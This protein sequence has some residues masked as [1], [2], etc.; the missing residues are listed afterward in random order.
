MRFNVVP[1]AYCAVNMSGQNSSDKVNITFWNLGCRILIIRNKRRYT[2]SCQKCVILK[3]GHYSVAESETLPK[4]I[5]RAIL[6]LLKK[7]TTIPL[8]LT[9]SKLHI[10]WMLSIVSD[11]LASVLQC[12]FHLHRSIILLCPSVLHLHLPLLWNIRFFSLRWDHIS[13]VL[14]YYF[15]PLFHLVRRLIAWSWT[16]YF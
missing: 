10:L 3:C 2:M 15:I 12:P 8:V 6:S 11:R 13:F 9:A 14:I 16:I 4:K 1:C 7:K 5:V